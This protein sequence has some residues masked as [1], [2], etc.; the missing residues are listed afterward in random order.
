MK[1][2]NTFVAGFALIGALGFGLSGP[3]SGA[4]AQSGSKAAGQTGQKAYTPKL[5]SAER[6]A[7]M[8]AL[9]PP[10]QKDV[11]VPVIFLRGRPRSFF[12]RGRGLGISKRDSSAEKTASRCPKVFWARTA[13]SAA[14]CRHCCDG[15]AKSG[16]WSRT[17]PAQAMWNGKTGP[18]STTRPPKSP[19]QT[20]PSGN[21]CPISGGVVRG[22]IKLWQ[23]G[24]TWHCKIGGWQETCFCGRSSEAA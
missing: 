17:S 12:P 23:R 15:S 21:A 3:Q 18:K 5:G 8:D 22:K 13:Q 6:T 20:G 4:W 16:K 11:G 2:Q 14:T 24:A 19:T 9:R 7:I 1:I 10:V